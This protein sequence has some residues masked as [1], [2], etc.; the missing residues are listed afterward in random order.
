[1]IQRADHIH[2]QVSA[3]VAATIDVILDGTVDDIAEAFMELAE[4]PASR[5]LVELFL[6]VQ[7]LTEDRDVAAQLEACR[8]PLPD[9][10]HAIVEAIRTEDLPALAEA[11]NQTD[12]ERLIEQVLKLVVALADER[13]GG[14]ADPAD[15]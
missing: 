13:D 1:M 3:T 8:F 6:W 9:N 5:V 12:Y 2:H 4:F 15:S 10:A 7:D 11:T 14:Q